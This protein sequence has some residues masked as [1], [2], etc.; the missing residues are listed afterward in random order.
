MQLHK[1][2]CPHLFHSL[3][4][5]T[6]GPWVLCL[7]ADIFL[8]IHKHAVTV[9]LWEILKSSW[10]K[11][12]SS[13]SKHDQG[14]YN[15]LNRNLKIKFSVFWKLSYLQSWFSV[16]KAQIFFFPTCLQPPPT[17]IVTVKVGQECNYNFANRESKTKRWGQLVAALPGELSNCH[18]LTGAIFC[19]DWKLHPQ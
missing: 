19:S 15:I 17:E 9:L 8:P 14:E 10:Q 5:S 13:T 18:L 6:K 12:G 7:F 11:G 16:L 2:M 1:Q 4:P 3:F